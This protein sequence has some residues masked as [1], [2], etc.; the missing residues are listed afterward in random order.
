MLTNPNDIQVSEYA[1]AI[2]VAK[3]SRLAGRMSDM[4]FNAHSLAK[5][6]QRGST[7]IV[8]YLHGRKDS[9][10]ADDLMRVATTLECTVAYLELETDDPA[11]EVGSLV[12]LDLPNG[13]AWPDDIPKPA[14]II[15][16]ATEGA[17]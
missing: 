7:Y 3:R 1:A 8:D 5:A 4:G 16:A 13:A 17:P 9:F 11:E 12:R 10:R 2:A 14:N 15:H 6:M